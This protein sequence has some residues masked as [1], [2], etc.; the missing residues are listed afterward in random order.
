[1]QAAT[2][3]DVIAALDAK[4]HGKE[5]KAVCP[6]CSHRCLSVSTGAKQPW[7][8][9]CLRGC[10]PGSVF[11]AVTSLLSTPSRAVAP[12]SPKAKTTVAQPAWQTAPWHQWK[13]LTEKGYQRIVEMRD[14]PDAG[15]MPSYETLL[16]FGFREHK[17]LVGFPIRLLGDDKVDCIKYFTPKPHS[18]PAYYFDGP[19]HDASRLYTFQVQPSTAQTHPLK[20]PPGTVAE[21]GEREYVV[22]PTKLSAVQRRKPA[23]INPFSDCFFIVEGIWDTLAL[24]QLGYKGA[25]LQA[26]SQSKIHAEALQP[27]AKNT[28][29]FLMLD[30][31]EPAQ[32][33]RKKILPLLPENS[34]NVEYPPLT[35]DL[36]TLL[37][38]SDE[39]TVLDAFADGVRRTLSAAHEQAQNPQ[40]NPQPIQFPSRQF[41][42][43]RADSIVAEPLEFIYPQ[44]VPQSAL[45]IICGHQDTGKGVL[46]ASLVTS[47]TTGKNWIDKENT[48]P[49]SD[50]IYLS[51]E[52]S[53][54]HTLVPRFAV[55]GADL[56]RIHFVDGTIVQH[57]AES[58][59]KQL[60]SLAT[61]LAAL[62]DLCRRTNAR[63]VIIDPLLS[64]M[65]RSVRANDSVEVRA[66][67]E[68]LQD[69]AD[70]HGIAVVGIGHF[71]KNDSQQV[72]NRLAG[73]AAF[74]QTPRAV[75][76]IGRDK[77]DPSLRFF[78]NQKCNELSDEEKHGF[79]WRI[80]GK[81]FKFPNGSVKSKP[82]AVFDSASS[83]TAEQACSQA[84]GGQK[85]QQESATDFIM[86]YLTD[87]QWHAS[88]KM[89]DDCIGTGVSAATYNIVSSRLNKTERKIRFKKFGEWYA[90]LVSDKIPPDPVADSE[91]QEQQ[92]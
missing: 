48:N 11:K 86:S 50:V 37:G 32:K 68:P 87:G 10:E 81:D 78:V 23:P 59:M 54:R 71:N 20:I 84:E 91:E 36:C 82:V 17:Q 21:V 72:I 90:C 73:S 85:S 66:V 40:V 39:D 45:T 62:A 30:N 19:E 88:A 26:T 4:Q 60:V 63:L 2:L 58:S 8:V 34:F 5:W 69:F 83:Q 43:T 65:G 15:F 51:A 76:I 1:M 33:A 70:E 42:V 46:I 7:V 9:N 25:G 18:K 61:D 47:L 29:V 38:D 27:L 13:D 41:L 74:S 35:H 57:S 12:E 75:W 64:F 3:D 89:K 92:F 6:V 53:V 77:D 49:P 31:D 22:D 56:K 80:I 24:W 55:A 28:A 14:R 79:K 52:D 16:A 44:R 67:L